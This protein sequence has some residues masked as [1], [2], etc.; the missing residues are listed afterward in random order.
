MSSEDLSEVRLVIVCGTH[1]EWCAGTGYLWSPAGACG[2]KS[3][4]GTAG[5]GNDADPVFN[6]L[7]AETQNLGKLWVVGVQKQHFQTILHPFCDDWNRIFI[8]TKYL[9]RF[10]LSHTLIL[11]FRN[12]SDQAKLLFI[13]Q[14]RAGGFKNSFLIIILYSFYACIYF[15]YLYLSTNFWLMWHWRLE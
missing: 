1:R 15:I 12:W 5:W 13:R 10:V 3:L 2:P 6:T 8:I 11:F 7:P 14:I 4:S 9:Y